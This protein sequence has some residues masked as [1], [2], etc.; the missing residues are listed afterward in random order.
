MDNEKINEARIYDEVLKA[1]E[2]CYLELYSEEVIEGEI[3]EEEFIEVDELCQKSKGF[4]PYIEKSTN[5]VVLV[6]FLAENGA[7]QQSTIRRYIEVSDE[8][9]LK[10]RNLDKDNNAYKICKV[11]NGFA[12]TFIVF[13]A[14]YTLAKL[15]M[16]LLS[17]GRGEMDF[18]FTTLLTTI[19]YDLIF[20]SIVTFALS[21][22]I[23]LIIKKN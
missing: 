22:I 3:K 17:V 23:K 14:L 20:Y 16:F 2:L 10:V 19:S 1:D 5:K 7:I 13:F 4:Y 21:Y 12:I 9:L 6:K 15:F 18:S 11:I 8:D